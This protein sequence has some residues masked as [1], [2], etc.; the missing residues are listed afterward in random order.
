M[1]YLGF[2]YH[3]IKK[4]NFYFII[5]VYTDGSSYGNP[6][7]GGIGIIIKSYNLYKEFT[8]KF[9]HTTNN[10][11]ELYAIIYAIKIINKLFYYS[12]N[13]YSDSKYIINTINYNYKKNKNY[14]LWLKL[15][16]LKINRINF[17]W[18]KGHN[19]NYYNEKCN[20]LARN[21]I[22]NKKKKNKIDKFYESNIK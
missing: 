9:R 22:K 15:F 14:D 3:I 13:I 18:I 20:I 4:E 1:K 17:I 5:N 12:S 6:G 8:Y 16:N 19:N 7:P 2:Y 21:V 11:M 10:R